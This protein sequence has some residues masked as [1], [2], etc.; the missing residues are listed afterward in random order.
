MMKC[1]MIGPPLYGVRRGRGSTPCGCRLR[2]F[3]KGVIISSFLNGRKMGGIA[4]NSGRTNGRVGNGRRLV[5]LVMIGGSFWR[6]GSFRGVVSPLFS[7]VF[8]R[9]RTMTCLLLAIARL[10]HGVGM[11]VFSWGLWPFRPFQRC[12]IRDFRERRRR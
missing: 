8:Q 11:W 6:N 4:T 5:K 10:Y 3:I 1:G 2:L 7:R 12:A 9:V